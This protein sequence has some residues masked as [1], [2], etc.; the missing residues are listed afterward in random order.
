MAGKLL[1]SLISLSLLQGAFASPTRLEARVSGTLDS[2]IAEESPFALKGILANTGSSGSQAAGA[3]SGIVVASPSKSNPDYFYTWT[4]DAAL[5]M[6]Q[7]IEQFIAGDTSLQSIIEDY[8]SSQAHIQTVSNPSG[9][10]S[11]GGL[12]EPKFYANTTAFT[13]AWGRPQRDG[14]ALRATTLIAYGQWLVDNGY[15]SLALSNVWPIVQNDLAYV[16]QYWNQTGFDLWEEVNGSSFFTIAAQHRA[17]VEG[18][19]FAKSVGKSCADCISQA[20]QV[21]CYLQSFWTGSYILAN[22]D[23]SRSGKDANSLLGSIHTFD[24]E[25]ACDDSTFQPCSSRALANHKVVTDSFRSVYDIN[26]DIDAGKAVAVGRYPEDSYMGGNP[27]WLCTFAAAEILYDALYQ[28]NKTGTITIDSTSLDFFKGVYSSAAIGNYSSSS[29]AYSSIISA[30][31]TYADGYLS[32]AQNYAPSN[33]TLS[34]QFDKSTGASISAAN[35]TWSYAAFLSV[36][37]RRNAVVPAAWGETS[38]SSVPATCAPTSVTGTYI[39]P[40][41]TNWPTTLSGSSSAVATTTALTRKSKGKAS[42]PST[43][44]STAFK[45][46]VKKTLGTSISYPIATKVAINSA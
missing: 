16:T 35:L 19:N 4:R 20:P 46:S 15:T 32:I 31:K 22:F 13:G 36:V 45:S 33:L 18:A 9:D 40:T 12:G 6:K 27:W 10:L 11:T 23:S 30:V 42:R 26:S 24:P 37:N 5:T 25:A 17:L 38:A 43:P 34:E 7:L 39:T 8:I 44:A 14:P 3:S 2:W 29:T 1:L 21:L 41:A 28:W